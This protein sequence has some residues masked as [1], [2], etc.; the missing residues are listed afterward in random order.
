[1]KQEKFS[2]IM[3]T[4]THCFSLFKEQSSYMFYEH[5]PYLGKA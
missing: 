1:M 2:K 5:L 3:K 4:K